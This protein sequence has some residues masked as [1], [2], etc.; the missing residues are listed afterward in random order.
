[1]ATKIFLNLPVKDLSKSVAFFTALGY[2]FDPQY[3]DEN[4]TCMIVGE[5]IFVM[6]LVEEFFKTFITTDIADAT[7]STEAI[8]ALSVENKGAVDEVVRKAVAAGA[9]TPTPA[10]DHGFMY[11][12]MIQD[13]DGHLWEYF[14]MDPDALAR[15]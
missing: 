5:D 2:S 4:A 14:Y 7:K 15:G 10:V 6:L 8:I 12:A 11:Q 9:T 13:P 3:T 1:M